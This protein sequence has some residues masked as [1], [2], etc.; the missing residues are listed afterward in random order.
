MP[1]GRN[2]MKWYFACNENPDFFPLI[3][4]AVN[5]AL[6]NTTLEPH[7]IYDGAQ[8]KLTDWLKE[9]GVKIISYRVSFYENL[10]KYYSPEL[11]SIASGA[12]L[13]CDIPLIEKDSDYVLYTD[14]DVLFLKDFDAQIRPKYFACA[15]QENKRNFKDFNTGVML[16]NVKELRQ[17]HEKFCAFISENLN[18]LPTF[19]Q[20]AFQIFY[21]GKCSELPLTYNHK[22][23][24]GGVNEGQNENVV[25]VHFHGCKPTDFA[26]DERLKKLPYEHERLYRKNPQAYD[27]YL[28][29]F[30][31]YCPEIEYN[32]ESLEKLKT[33]E[34]PLDKGKKTPLLQRIAN[35]FLKISKQFFVNFR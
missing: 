6:K 35:K 2:F 12:F 29:L 32:C 18:L 5:S 25:I 30:K 10:Q 22:P 1:R 3:M 17:S 4:G 11:L 20:S 7:F 28:N 26:S 21:S 33:G 14:C 27:F 23:Y 16:I 31:K 8:N 13:R 34:Y 15:P 9:R 19:D 24:W